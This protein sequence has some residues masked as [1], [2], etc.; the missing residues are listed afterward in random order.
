[1]TEYGL[2]NNVRIHNSGGSLRVLV[3][4]ELEYVLVLFQQSFEALSLGNPQVPRA[5]IMSRR[6]RTVR[7]SLWL[8]AAPITILWN[9]VSCSR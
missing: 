9:I 4:E 1:M 6:I 7:T 8:P 3:P 2:F 5:V